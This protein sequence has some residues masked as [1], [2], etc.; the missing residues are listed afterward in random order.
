MTPDGFVCLP[1][2][3]PSAGSWPHLDERYLEG[4]RRHVLEELLGGVG[5]RKEGALNQ[6][7]SQ[8]AA[9]HVKPPGPLGHVQVRFGPGK[10]VWSCGV[11]ASASEFEVQL[12]EESPRQVGH[13]PR[14]G[15][16]LHRRGMGHGDSALFPQSAWDCRCECQL[17]TVE[18]PTSGGAK[19][20]STPES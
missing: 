8:N 3:K 9:N 6:K 17:G 20:T 7:Q 13:L 4:R 19:W 11:L 5:G 16:W 2:E 18:G 10:H 15:R 12:P 1:C 14:G